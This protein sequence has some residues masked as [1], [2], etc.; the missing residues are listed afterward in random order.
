MANETDNF[1]SDDSIEVQSDD[2]K[3]ETYYNPSTTKKQKGETN[4]INRKV[5]KKG[6]TKTQ[7]NVISSRLS[8]KERIIRLKKKFSSNQKTAEKRRTP[9]TKNHNDFF[10]QTSDSSVDSMTNEI[11]SNKND[12]EIVPSSLL[13]NESEHSNDFAGEFGEIESPQILARSPYSSSHCCSSLFND[14]FEEILSYLSVLQKQVS[15]LEGY[16]VSQRNINP[17]IK[18]EY[19]GSIQNH[20]DD[21]FVDP[22]LVLSQIQLPAKS[23]SA[24]DELESN[25]INPEYHQ[26][27]VQEFYLIFSYRLHDFMCDFSLYYI[28]FSLESFE[29]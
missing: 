22:N 13:G 3:D 16:V 2:D 27:L 28:G 21:L 10:E 17:Q 4:G 8:C 7:N 25:L 18:Y 24:V 11:T 15:R 23:K 19:N 20:K 26:K 12:K 29:W 5:K 14:K 1:Q 6:K 9:K